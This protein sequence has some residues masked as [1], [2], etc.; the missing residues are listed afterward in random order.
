MG[1]Y[2][3]GRCFKDE[4][5]VG[6]GGD[7]QLVQSGNSHYSLQCGNSKYCINATA[8]QGK[9]K[10][11]PLGH[12]VNWPGEGQKGNCQPSY[13]NTTGL[14]FVRAK[15]DMDTEGKWMELLMLYNDRGV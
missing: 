6:Y 13:Q 7:A 3:R 14:L 11:V 12:F 5:L 9:I 15:R 4:F 8:L 1:L 10:G 2:F